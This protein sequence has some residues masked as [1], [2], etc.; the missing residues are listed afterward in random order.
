MWGPV[1]TLTVALVLTAG[2]GGSWT[3]ADRASTQDAVQL[4]LL[5]DEMLDGG[6]ARALE[7]AAYCSEASVLLRHGGALPDAGIRC[8]P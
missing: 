7:R 3:A 1:R 8:Q 4:N 2:C 5:V 6:A